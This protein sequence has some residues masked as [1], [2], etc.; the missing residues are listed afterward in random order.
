MCTRHKLVLFDEFLDEE[1]RKASGTRLPAH[2][3]RTRFLRCRRVG[4]MTRAPVAITVPVTCTCLSIRWVGGRPSLLAPPS[5]PV[6]MAEDE[7]GSPRGR[8]T[9]AMN[10]RYPDT[11]KSPSRRPSWLVSLLSRVM[12]RTGAGRHVLVPPLEIHAGDRSEPVG[13]AE[14]PGYTS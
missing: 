6:R 14:V 11:C 3:N 7:T 5:A 8:H 4:P 13:S 1:L 2:V 9:H 12:H 10:E